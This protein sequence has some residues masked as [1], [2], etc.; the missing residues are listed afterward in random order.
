MSQSEREKTLK[1]KTQK[2]HEDTVRRKEKMV[3][4]VREM[5]Q[6]GFSQ[7]RISRE[8]N[9]EWKTVK[10]YLDPDFNSV[11]KMHGRK[12]KSILDGYHETIEHLLREGLKCREIEEQL[13]QKGYSGSSSLIRM[14]ISK[15]KRRKQESY[16]NQYKAVS[17]DFLSR[18]HIIKLLYKPLKE[19]KGLTQEM[20]ARF[21]SHYPKAA[22]IIELISEFKDILKSSAINR[23]E[24]WIQKAQALDSDEISSFVNGVQRDKNAVVNAIMLPYSNGL[25]EGKINKLKTIKRVMYGRCSFD[26]LKTKVLLLK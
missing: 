21:Q 19:I 5:Y 26:T 15:I 3:Q 24:P 20:Y 13:R 12:K 9:L 18:N 8:L 2:R 22:G 10:K 7:R 25:A 6:N 17:Y 11:H 23:L 4:S 16:I 14:H 1:S